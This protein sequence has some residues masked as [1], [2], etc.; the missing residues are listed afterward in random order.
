MDFC[1]IGRVK[2]AEIEDFVLK[3][4]AITIDQVTEI[5]LRNFE[6]VSRRKNRANSYDSEGKII[7]L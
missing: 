2:H 7:E 6:I 5:K 3:T 4:I 1:T